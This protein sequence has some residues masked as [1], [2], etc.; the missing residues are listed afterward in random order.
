MAFS[1]SRKQ[2]QLDCFF[3]TG[4]SPHH[5]HK[6]M[7]KLAKI[8]HRPV[9]SLDVLTQL[10]SFNVHTL[11][12][13]IRKLQKTIMP[14]QP[15][16]MVH[17]FTC[18]TPSPKKYKS[19]SPKYLQLSIKKRNKIEYFPFTINKLLAKPKCIPPNSSLK[20]GKMQIIKKSFSKQCHIRITS[21]K[22]DARTFSMRTFSQKPQSH[23]S[24]GNNSFL[25][26]W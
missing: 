16:T 6:K 20:I 23:E 21:L 14:L 24:D 13:K 10:Q 1:N 22:K 25:S 8:S 19:K 7:P 12:E 3:T 26:G 11:I 9:S 17:A 2:N 15:T 5:E 4:D 18:T